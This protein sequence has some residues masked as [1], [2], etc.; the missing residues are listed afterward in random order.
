MLSP[1]SVRASFFL[2]YA[3]LFGTALVTFVESLRT[4]SRAARHILNLETAVSLVAGF[5][6]GAFAAMAQREDFAIEAITPLRY[7]DWAITTPILLLVLLLFFA[8]HNGEALRARDFAV[9][10][11][12]NYVMLGAGYLAETGR[13]S[14]AA[15]AAVGFA[16]F[17]A[18]IAFMYA[19]FVHG[20]VQRHLF[21]VFAAFA[22][23]WGAYGA[24]YLAR[25]A[26]D[27]NAA[28]NAL[29][30]LAKVGIGFYLWGTYG[31]VMEA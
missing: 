3:L 23:I 9:V 17:F 13:W 20:A 31:G 29:D 6:Y 26:A 11:A 8:H 1:A 27:K 24:A 30:V 2:V 25:D 28:Y 19:R 22:A 5:F 4:T 7:A 18:M 16:A 14:R 12:L 15:G 10:V 21:G